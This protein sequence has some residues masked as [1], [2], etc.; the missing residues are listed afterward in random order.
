MG[1]SV[2]SFFQHVWDAAAKTPDD[3]GVPNCRSLI[4]VQRQANRPNDYTVIDPRPT[5]RQVS[6]NTVKAYRAIQGIDLE[7]DDLVS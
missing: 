6:Q 7:L 3:Y 1:I 5:I 2:A 4:V